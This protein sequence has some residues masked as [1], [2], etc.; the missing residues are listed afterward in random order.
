MLN[1]KKVVARSRRS[2]V[3]TIE[4]LVSH[5]TSGMDEAI[6]IDVL[7]V[8]DDVFPPLRL[9]QK[10]QADSHFP[11]SSIPLSAH[12]LSIS[13][14]SATALL[15]APTFEYFIL[16]SFGARGVSEEGET[17]GSGKADLADVENGQG[18]GDGFEKFGLLPCG[19]MRTDPVLQH[20]K[21]LERAATA[22]GGDDVLSALYVSGPTQR[23]DVEVREIG[24]DGEVER[25]QEQAM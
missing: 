21:C 10:S 5:F 9:H 11:F 1:L 12:N 16:A 6:D 13:S 14:S 24:E 23:S 4:H 17:V 25:P 19:G 22:N 8:A 20:R 7:S 15:D 18:G 2:L 3:G